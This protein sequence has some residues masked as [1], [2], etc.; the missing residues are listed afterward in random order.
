MEVLILSCKT[1]GGH[2][3]AGVAVQ[4]ELIRRGHRT[5]FLD[6]YQL[7][8]TSLDR[9]VGNA[10]V[11]LVQ[12]CPGA[13][14]VLYQLGEAF[15]RLPFRSPVYFLNIPVAEK[16]GTY[17]KKNSFDCIVTTHL[18]PAEMLTSL[19][20][21]GIE[22][23]PSIF[24]AT[25]YTCI[26]FT[27]E[28]DCDY[29]VIPSEELTDEFVK[30]GI[31][32]EKIRPLGIPVRAGFRRVMNLKPRG[33][34]DLH[35]LLVSGGSIGAGSM[36]RTLKRLKGKLKG[37]KDWLCIVICGN[38]QRLYRKLK[39]IYGNDQQYIILG[40]TECMEKYMK[41]SDLFL[42]KP[43]GLSS[44]EAAVLGVPLLHIT[45]IPGCES[46]NMKFFADRGMSFNGCK[47]ISL[48]NKAY[49]NEMYR[50]Q[51]KYCKGDE[52]EKICDFLEKIKK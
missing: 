19:K 48:E 6:P 23:P 36:E 29:Y 39:R 43:G 38:N 41:I 33:K 22:L 52:T 34:K 51:K 27:E 47:K 20:R 9:A 30:R 11:R 21:S 44:S 49:L 8:G 28:T 10:Y 50:N 3:M 17:L 15:R 5:V 18:F 26:P 42:S 32:E 1:G 40:K 2:N 16:L 7:T 35:Y 46:R 14:G 13:F 24:I 45:P 31:P 37:R 4:E 12:R 25:D